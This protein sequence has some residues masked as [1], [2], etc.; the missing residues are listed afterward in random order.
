[1]EQIASSVTTMSDGLPAF[2]IVAAVL[3]I[4]VTMGSIAEPPEVLGSHVAA[5]LAGTFLGV[6]LAYGI[7][8]A[9]RQQAAKP[10]SP[11]RPSTTS[12]SRPACSPSCR[13]MPPVISVEFARKALYS[14]ERPSFTHGRA[15]GREHAGRRLGRGEAPGEA[16]WPAPN[17]QPIVIKKVKKG[18]GHGHH[19]GG[20]KIAYADFVTAMMAFF[21][22]LWLL[23]ATTE[24]QKLGI[25]N[26]FMPTPFTK[27]DMVGSH[28]ISGGQTPNDTGPLDKSPMSHPDVTLSMTM[29]RDDHSD[30]E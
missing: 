15:G 26:F 1:M 13:A 14:H 27:N 9:R 2:G 22:L 11:P 8:G 23:A 10:T 18:H 21:L 19:G 28:G 12:A 25:A 29:P 20:W 16:A 17:D 6:L 24:E 3:G 5:A 30:E 4:I 7:V